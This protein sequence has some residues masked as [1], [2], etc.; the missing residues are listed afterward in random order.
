MNTKNSYACHISCSPLQGSLLSQNAMPITKNSTTQRHHIGSCNLITLCS[1]RTLTHSFPVLNPFDQFRVVVITNEG[2]ALFG[3]F[4]CFIDFAIFPL[5]Q[6]FSVVKISI[7]GLNRG[8]NTILLSELLALT[9]R[10]FLFDLP[11]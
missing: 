7:D 6:T 4:V 9:T 11:F 10:C 3:I 1:C 8:F 5:D 2:P